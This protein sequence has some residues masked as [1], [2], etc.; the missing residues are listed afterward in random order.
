[1]DQE[2]IDLM[3]MMDDDDACFDDQRMPENILRLWQI[4]NTLKCP[5]CLVV[6][7]KVFLGKLAMKKIMN[8][9]DFVA[10]ASLHLHF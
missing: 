3:E 6:T 9:A 7:L 10:C 1:M 5:F 2:L 8:Q 4:Q